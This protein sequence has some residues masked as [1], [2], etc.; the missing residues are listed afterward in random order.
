LENKITIHLIYPT[1]KHKKSSPWSVGNNLVEALKKNFEV[2]THDWADSHQIEPGPT[3]ILL[4]HPHPKRNTVFRNSFNFKWLHRYVICPFTTNPQQMYFVERYAQYA[5]AFFA[6]CGPYW[7][8]QIKNSNYS[9][10]EDRFIHLNMGVTA[11]D[12]PALERSFAEPGNRKFAYIG[13]SLALKGT[14]FLEEIAARC[15]TSE[16]GWIGSSSWLKSSAKK[17][18]YLNLDTNEGRRAIQDYDFVI[19]PGR[20]DANPTVL[21]EAMCLGLIPVCTKESGYDTIENFF[22][23]DYGNLQQ[24]LDLID[25]LQNLDE[26]ELESRR[27]RNFRDV[28]FYSWDAFTGTVINR[29]QSDISQRIVVSRL[30]NPQVINV[31]K[32]FLSWCSPYRWWRSKR[33]V[34]FLE[35]RLYYVRGKCTGKRWSR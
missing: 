5:D 10:L 18:G 22:T 20:S 12:W 2:I 33:I 26:Q 7:A 21:L 34:K 32:F 15:K 8:K 13:S 29:I 17:V 4:G 31:P 1:D 23:L 14:P 28:N 3:D 35:N 9:Y 27:E 25:Y 30:T 16:I 19:S 24:A 6:I 11:S